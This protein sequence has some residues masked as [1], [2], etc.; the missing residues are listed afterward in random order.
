MNDR[1]LIYDCFSGIS[2]DMHIGAMLD[3]GVPEELLRTEL[4]RLPIAEEFELEVAR[5]DKLGIVGTQATIRIKKKSKKH[6]HLA[7]ITQIIKNSGYPPAVQDRALGIFGHVAVAEAKIHGVSIDDVHFHEV[8]A[9]DSVADIVAAA[10][11]LEHLGIKEAFVTTVE[12]GGGMVRCEHGLLPVPAPATSEILKG[13]P[14]KLGGV[15][16]EA[17]TPTGA[18]ILKHVVTGSK[19]P[20][21][22]CPEAIGYGLGQKDFAI[23]NVLR[24][25]LVNRANVKP[26]LEYINSHVL[27][28]QCNIDDMS[29]EAFE[30]LL[31]TLFERGAK[32]VFQTPV[33]MKKS[34]PG[35][36]LTVLC[37]EDQKDEMLATIF[38]HSSTIG[39]RTHAVERFMLPR[40]ILNVMTSFGEVGVK[41]VTLPGGVR[42]W[43]LEH[44][45]VADCA[46]Q[47]GTGYLSMYRKLEREVAQQLDRDE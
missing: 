47:Q 9:V 46:R 42:R 6:R 8:G 19:P 20:V 35:I 24:V 18:A 36:K 37:E 5:G 31:E 2:G 12:L 22:F 39:V 10:I 15:D 21:G 41:R 45:T 14:C 27:E 26:G 29:P 23:P 30:P 40:E 3:L 7:D 16:S 34:R 25:M 38:G 32:E 43:K 28:I 4:G 33:V 11:C 44:D 13:L 17:T 1:A